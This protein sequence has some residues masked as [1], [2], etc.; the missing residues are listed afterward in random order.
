MGHQDLRPVIWTGS[1]VGLHH[2]NFQLLRSNSYLL[3]R[4]LRR[5]KELFIRMQGFGFQ[6]LEVRFHVSTCIKSLDHIQRRQDQSL[7]AL[8]CHMEA[9]NTNCMISHM[10][11]QDL[12]TIHRQG[13]WEK[14]WPPLPYY[15][16]DKNNRWHRLMPIH[17]IYMLYK[18][19]V[20][21]SISSSNMYTVINV[22]KMMMKSSQPGTQPGIK[23]YCKI[24]S[25]FWL[26]NLLV[27]IDCHYWIYFLNFTYKLQFLFLAAW[28]SMSKWLLGLLP[29]Q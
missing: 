24:H 21:S 14:V 12:G 2:L 13:M 29:L 27:F 16:T 19:E 17:L 3:E 23:N 26:S 11:T 20:N 4:V 8:V 25:E 9:I 22:L 15:G 6:L 18:K 1:W 10:N 7:Y 28:I 5:S